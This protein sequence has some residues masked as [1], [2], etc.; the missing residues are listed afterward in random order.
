MFRDKVI[1]TYNLDEVA[2]S[3]EEGIKFLKEHNIDL[4]EIRTINGKNITQLSIKETKNL[5]EILNW[6]GLS[7]SSIASPLFK[8]YS[9]GQI[10]KNKADLFGVNP[11]LSKKEKKMMIRKVIDQACILGTDKVRIFSGLKPDKG[12][13]N[14]PKEESD[15]LIFALKVAKEKGVQLLLENEPACYISKIKDY[16]NIFISEKYKGL[17]AWFDIANVYEQG[18]TITQSDLD[19]LAPY[20]SYLH[21]KDPVAFMKHHY[22]PLGK[23]Y[24]NYK[25]IFDILES[26]INNSV[27]LSI[28]THVKDDKWNASHES[29]K[30]LHKL[31][32]TKRIQYALVG[33]GRISRKHFEAI[34]YN[35]NCTLIGLYD[36]DS[37]KTKSSALNHDC[38]AYKTYQNLL[39]DK[40]V[41]V[42]SICTPHLTHIN[43]VNQ[44]LNNKKKVLCEKPLAL[45]LKDINN[46]IL[47][48]SKDSDTFIVFQ[49]RF[50]PAVKK[51]Y[52]FE[53]KKL[54]EPQYI[55]ITI[56]WWRDIDYYKDW[57]GDEKASGGAFITQAIHSLDLITHFTKGAAIKNI[58]AI[59]T[60]TRDEIKIPDII[61]AIVEFEN[62]IICNIEVC[63]VTRNQNLESSFFVVGKKA[64]V[65]ITGVSLSDFVH[66]E[67]DKSSKVDQ[68]FINKNFHYYGNGHLAL[69]K[70][71]ANHFLQITDPDDH[72]LTKPVD[73]VNTLILIED[74]KKSLNKLRGKLSS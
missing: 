35:E 2:D 17:R 50:N 55:A 18:K 27:Y 38:I 61:V 59:Q 52:N 33:V 19:K 43:L 28:E 25:R 40:L 73:L 57:H 60:K 67:I 1:I 37:K 30:Y 63:L 71:H 9:T 54:G 46:Y 49:N 53:I 36:I 16:I 7:I 12:N 45:N 11:L 31:L 70:T 72:L 74:I 66:P 58:K 8:W 10:S 39:D 62:G 21:I 6:N 51:L 56:R 13:Y 65:K 14:F 4:A 34:K 15:L 44:A 69:Y 42:V 29:L 41:K 24:I 26:S 64:S 5:K 23:G 32:N 68:N 3:L 20:I 22:V 47:K 48:H